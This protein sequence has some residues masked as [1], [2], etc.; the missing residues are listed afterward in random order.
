MFTKNYN[1]IILIAGLGLFFNSYS[2]LANESAG[3]LK[4]EIFYRTA[5]REVALGAGSSVY[6][7]TASEEAKNVIKAA[8]K[9]DGLTG[10]SHCSQLIVS[11]VADSS[12]LAIFDNIPEGS[13]FIVSEVRWIRN[14]FI[15]NKKLG[16][17]VTGSA[18]VRGKDNP[19]CIVSN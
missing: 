12:G 3:I 17:I 9:Q 2:L 8:V 7:L 13:Y 18:I 1:T 11:T 10:L 19:K 5:Q 4:C 6:L 16:G 14:G 15:K